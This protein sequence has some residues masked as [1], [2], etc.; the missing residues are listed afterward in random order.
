MLWIMK[1]SR[2]EI[3]VP[4]RRAGRP[5]SEVAHA[6]ILDAAIALVREVGYDLV[7]MDGVAARAGVGK[8]TLY[9]RFATKEALVAEAI[10]RI[11]RGIPSPDTGSVRGDL[12]QLLHVALAMYRD[13]ATGPLLSGF[14]AAMARSERIASVI[15][16]GFAARWRSAVHEA[17][18]NGVK[19]GELRK[20]LDL[21]L[22]TDLVSAPMFYRYLMTGGP[23]DERLIDAVVDAAVRA[24]AASAPPARGER[25]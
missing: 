21:D 23:V 7:T 14:V 10:E 6:A 17:L 8:A 20:R 24:Y 5:R 25:S 9:R 16:G 13:P 19:R 18:A 1:R 15:R 22:V 11:M 12:R 2:L 3:K 4:L